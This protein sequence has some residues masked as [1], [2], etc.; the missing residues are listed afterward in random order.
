MAVSTVDVHIQN[1]AGKGKRMTAKQIRYFGTKRQKAAL[2]AN[3]SKKRKRHSVKRRQA[4]A[5]KRRNAAPRRRKHS[6]RRNT[7]RPHQGPR[8]NPAPRKRRRK[9][10]HRRRTVKRNPELVSFLLGNPAT[11]RR[12]KVAH[13]RRRKKRSAA[14][15]SNAGT[16]RRRTVHH[17]S[18]RNPA[19]IPLK[20]FA[21]GG[22]GV[23]AGFLGS[24][25]LPQMFMG[26]ANTGVTGYALT[27]AAGIGLTILAHMFVKNRSVTFGVGAGAAANLLR[28]IV[29]DQTPFGPYLSNSGMGDYMVANWGPPRMSNGLQSAMAEAPGTPWSGGGGGMIATSSGISAQ[30]MSDIRAGRPC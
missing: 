14:S 25:A 10:S 30:D 16:R 1:P 27:A 19:G 17:S 15:R 12:K 26:A 5:A 22:A 18:R 11:K 28:R 24:A 2:R 9:T 21:F 3:R 29:T 6:V 4:P 8:C 20:D 13:T 23:L 7:A